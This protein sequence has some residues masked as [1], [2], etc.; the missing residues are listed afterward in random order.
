MASFGLILIESAR[1]NLRLTRIFMSP[2]IFIVKSLYKC[3][4]NVKIV[5]ATCPDVYNMH[6]IYHSR[7]IDVLL[8]IYGQPDWLLEFPGLL[9]FYSEFVSRKR[10]SSPFFQ[11]KNPKAQI[12]GPTCM[13][14]SLAVWFTPVFIIKFK[15]FDHIDLFTFR[16]H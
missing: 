10:T 5:Q 16:A 3:P 7:G 8:L 13:L 2:R 9:S 6:L 15:I 12:I 4:Y 1:S 14:V 11:S